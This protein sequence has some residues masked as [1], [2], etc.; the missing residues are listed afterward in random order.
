[1]RMKDVCSPVKP[2]K[3][4]AIPLASTALQLK[5]VA[6][7]RANHSP[8]QT[9]A[10]NYALVN[11]GANVSL[12]F[13]SIFNVLITDSAFGT[14]TVNSFSWQI[15]RQKITI[16]ASRLDG[17]GHVKLNVYVTYISKINL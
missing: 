4:R 16:N 17:H 6:G 2:R 8:R 1:M 9:D 3:V 5:K 11:S 7:Q 13:Q 12:I 15:D 14:V 10:E